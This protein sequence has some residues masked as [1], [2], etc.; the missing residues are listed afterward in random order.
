[1]KKQTLLNLVGLFILTTLLTGSI[2]TALSVTSVNSSDITKKI[3]PRILKKL[4]NT[5]FLTQSKKASLFNI[6]VEMKEQAD[7]SGADRLRAKEQ[8]TA[9]V[10]KKLTTTAQSSQAKLQAFLKASQIPFHSFYIT[11]AVVITQ[12][13]AELID[14]LAQREDVGRI[15]L[16]PEIR[17]NFPQPES[18]FSTLARRGGP[19]N[20]LIRIGATKVWQMGYTGKGIVVA[21]QDTG[22]EW[23]HPGLVKNYRGLITSDSN[24]PQADHNY[25]WHDAIQ[26]PILP[27]EGETAP[28]PSKCGYDLKAPCDDD[29]HGSHTM[30]TMIGHDEQ[31]QTGVAPDAKWIACRNMDAGT[32]R[33]STYIDCF[34]FFLAPYPMGGNPQL[35]GDP[36]KAADI[37][38][39]SWGC[40]QEEECNGDEI[41]PVVKALKKAGIM[42]VVSAGNDGPGCSTIQAAPAHYTDEVLSVG[43]FN[44]RDDKI[45]SFSS[46]GPSKFDGGIGPDIVAPG[47]NI[48]STIP[49]GIYAGAFWSGT[50]MER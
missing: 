6:I 43:A 16:N 23:T 36:S 1:M 18:V 12:A 47:V 3:D 8:K 37:I 39:N 31:N 41:L 38:N 20:N 22:V 32:G 26:T 25:N 11:N 48:R 34:E 2:F 40:P 24:G 33:P 49:G 28:S 42:V 14:T 27:L 29:E 46:R 50:S 9:Y 21:G 4:E 44:H 10:Y 13:K 15:I 5:S 7:L 17:Q 30:G 19:E 45:A 35:D